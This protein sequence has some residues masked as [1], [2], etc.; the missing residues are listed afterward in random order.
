MV[1]VQRVYYPL[2]AVIGIPSNIMTFFIFWRRNCMISRSSTFYLMAMAVADTAVLLFIVVLELTIKYHTPEPF[3]SQ[4]PWCSVRDIF[5]YGASNASI[6]LV[7]IFTAERFLAINTWSLKNRLCTPRC[8]LW[9]IATVFVVSHLLA[10]PYYWAYMSVY[11]AE[12]QRWFCIYRPDASTLY[13]HSLVGLQTLLSHILPFLIILILNG[14]ILRQISL[15]NRVHAT[16]KTDSSRGQRATPLLRSRKRKS[17]VLLVTVSMSFVLL[18]V[19][20]SVTQIIVRT[21]HVPDRDDYGLAINVAAD[22][23]TMLS[24]SNA[25]I[26]MYLYACTQAKFR[27]EVIMSLKQACSLSRACCVLQPHPDTT[28]SHV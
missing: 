14:L 4:E 9:A 15:S 7:V 19:M 20:R 1:H 11:N 16:P 3:W 8:A 28:P 10:I 2:L 12:L 5:N 27:Q 18:S 6:W 25:A 13:V 24:L 22:L 21:I 17:V 26:N 23:G